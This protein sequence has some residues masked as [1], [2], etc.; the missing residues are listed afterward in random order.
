MIL[1][2]LSG[3]KFKALEVTPGVTFHPGSSGLPKVQAR[4]L[5]AQGLSSDWADRADATDKLNP[6]HPFV[7][8]DPRT[9]FQLVLMWVWFL[10]RE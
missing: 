6:S 5:D 8:P 4:F 7:P 9:I 1:S 3:D 2:P 10:R